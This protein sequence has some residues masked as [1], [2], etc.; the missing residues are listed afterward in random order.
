MGL[1]FVVSRVRLGLGYTPDSPVHMWHAERLAEN[2]NLA[3]QRL[4]F[5][6][7]W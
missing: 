1:G 2:A 5:L 7:R 6:F 4:S 3:K